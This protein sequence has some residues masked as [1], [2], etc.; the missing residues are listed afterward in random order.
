MLVDQ[1]SFMVAGLGGG[2]GAWRNRVL[3]FLLGDLAGLCRYSIQQA[4]I[5]FFGGAVPPLC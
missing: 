1:G 4:W 5:P 3:L 2:G